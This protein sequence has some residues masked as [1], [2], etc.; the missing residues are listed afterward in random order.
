MFTKS[1]ML[2]DG[3]RSLL[4]I[5]GS[6]NLHK[7]S[8]RPLREPTHNRLWSIPG[9]FIYQKDILAKQHVMCWHPGLNAGIDRDRTIYAL[10]DGIMVITEEQY[11]PDW[12]YPLVKEVYL[13]RDGEKLA[14]PYKRYIHV[15][16]RRR[17]S[18][19]KLVDLV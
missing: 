19:F 11:K 3:P 12:T 15:I 7:S 13:N 18:E 2:R 5:L 10:T 14:P 17:V 9:E 1:L 16:P 8:Q 6:R 4:Q